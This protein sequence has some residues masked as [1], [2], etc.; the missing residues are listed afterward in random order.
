MLISS[1][2]ACQ[3]N[4][5]N[6]VLDVNTSAEPVVI[7]HKGLTR[8]EQNKEI[9]KSIEEGIVVNQ[10]SN[11]SNL[12][13]MESFVEKVQKDIDCTVQII[14]FTLEGEP[15]YAT[16][17][18]NGEYIEVVRSN[19]SRYTFKFIEKRVINLENKKYIQFVLIGENVEEI[20]LG[21]DINKAL[22]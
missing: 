5:N 6:K 14:N 7:V 2:I 10:L 12:S 17:N 1:L 20:I 9:K 19:Y 11:I 3:S 15:C 4:E 13:N 21:F 18:Y 16:L 22:K 8:E